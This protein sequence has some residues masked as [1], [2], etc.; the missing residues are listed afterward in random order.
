M[1]M[2]R[3]LILVAARNPAPTADAD[4]EKFWLQLDWML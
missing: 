4:T 1:I 2:N 3:A